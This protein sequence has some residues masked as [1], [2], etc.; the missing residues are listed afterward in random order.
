ML[1]LSDIHIWTCH[2]RPEA[3]NC[4]RSPLLSSALACQN[5]IIRQ[6]SKCSVT[7]LSSRSPPHPLASTSV[8]ISLNL[9]LNPIPAITSALDRIAADIHQANVLTSC[10]LFAIIFILNFRRR[11]RRRRL[12]MT[13]P[14]LRPCRCCPTSIRKKASDDPPRR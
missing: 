7:N 1:P 13:A 3:V 9:F 5:R 8:A 12:M 2:R 11:R 10:S 14:A 6:L 4:R